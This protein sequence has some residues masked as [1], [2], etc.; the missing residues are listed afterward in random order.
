MNP[1]V[2]LKIEKEH[3]EEEKLK[4][5]KSVIT[6]KMLSKDYHQKIKAMKNSNFIIIIK[7]ECI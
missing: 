5:L 2:L 7:D 1:K 6:A 3:L 4:K